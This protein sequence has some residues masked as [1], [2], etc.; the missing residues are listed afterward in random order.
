[1]SEWAIDSTED[2]L[3]EVVEVEKRV[4]WLAILIVHEANQRKDPSGIKIGGHQ[5]SSASC[6]SL[7]TA[8]YFN[9]LG[10]AD[11]ISVKP[12]ASPV[13]YAIQ[14]LLGNLRQKDL[15]SLR[16]FG[17]LQA[18]PSQTKNPE[19][20]DFSTG[21]VGLGAAAVNFSALTAQYLR[22]KGLLSEEGNFWAVVGDAELDEGNVWE[23]LAEP[24]ADEV[25]GIRWVVDLNR[26]SLDRVVP[27]LRVRRLE[28]LFQANGW[29]VVEAKYG[30]MLTRLFEEPG[31]EALRFRIDSM[32]NEEYQSVISGPSDTALDRL[33]LGSKDPQQIRRLLANLSDEQVVEALSALGG[34]DQAVLKEAFIEADSAPGPAVIF[35]YTV[36]G[37]GLPFAGDPMNHS[38]VMS[39]QQ[40]EKLASDLGI[41]DDWH[42]HLGPGDPGWEVVS[43]ARERLVRPEFEPDLIPTVPPSIDPVFSKRTS[44]QEAFGRALTQLAAKHSELAERVVTAAPDVSISTNLAGWINR[45]GSWRTSARPEYGEA[46]PLLRWSESPGGQHLE[47]GIS[48]MNLFGLLG[49]LGLSRETFG[50][51]LAPIGTVYDTFISR[52]LDSL[53][54]GLYCGASLV[55]VGTPSGVSLSP[56]GGAHQ[57][58]FTPGL[59]IALPGLL[60]YEPCFAKETEWVLLAAIRRALSGDGSSYLRLST[61]PVDQNLFPGDSETLR[62]QVLEGAYRIVDRTVEPGFEHD[63]AAVIFASGVTV[64]SA[65]RAS[66]ALLDEGV[67]ASVINVTSADQLYRSWSRSGKATIKEARHQPNPFPDLMYD[68]ELGVPAVSVADAHPHG[69]AFLGTALGVRSI[70]LGVSTF[71]ESGTVEE[72]HQKHQLDAESLVNAAISLV[73]STARLKEAEE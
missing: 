27:G 20:V 22:S 13:L 8:L 28:R 60:S 58:T 26:Q 32:P 16:A 64:P 34:H 43:R 29:R 52:G 18:Y 45:V 31:G 48:E 36:K 46:N 14:Y 35:A 24:L 6:V 9:H 44:S 71:G 59:G 61:L 12:H 57:S 37:W 67:Y 4:L 19:F 33:V 40:M 70:S 49:Q 73:D 10:A 15:S 41:G 63:V 66:E 62:R 53:I 69:L 65:C 68:H 1:M 56:E 30:Q 42:I 38:A 21:S 54:Y 17:G 72:L 39:D 5:A 2:L 3:D 7:L 55:I 23:A 11:R 51:N 25:P 47:L 50:V